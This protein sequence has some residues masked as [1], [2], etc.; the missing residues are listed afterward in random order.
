MEAVTTVYAIHTGFALVEPLKPLFAEL[1]P[2]VRVVNLVDESLLADA[3]A[4]GGLT[5]A[6]TRRILGYGTLAATSGA[7][8][9]FSCCSPVGD[10]ADL[11]ACAVKIPVVK[12]VS[13][14]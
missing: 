5:P 1:L 12:S 4:A 2:A 10:A 14:S 8:A 3:R 9:I 6:V 11:L 7:S 13:F